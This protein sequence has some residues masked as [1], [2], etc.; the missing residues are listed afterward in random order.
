MKN[1]NEGFDTLP[2]KVSAIYSTVDRIERLLTDHP[3]IKEE[4]KNKFLTVD[5]ASV[6]L[7]LAKQTI[8]GLV[9]ERKIPFI[10]RKGTKR[11]YFSQNDLQQW[12]MKDRKKVWK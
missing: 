11:L 5:E 9:S 3:G 8:Y 10:K 12:I 7:S 6:Y 1:Q 4:E 2:E